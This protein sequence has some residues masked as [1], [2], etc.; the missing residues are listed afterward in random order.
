MRNPVVLHVEHPSIT[1]C[2]LDE[3]VDFEAV[4]KQP[5]HTLFTLV[6]R[7]VRSHLFLLSRLSAALHDPGFKRAVVER[8]PA[9][10]ILAEARRLE[11]AFAR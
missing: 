3:P 8:A 4:D 2:F 9:E 6:S 10:T 5:V 7:T 11:A 1:L